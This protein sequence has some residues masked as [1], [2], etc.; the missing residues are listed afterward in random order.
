MAA[1]KISIIIP[2]K[3]GGP[4]KALEALSAVD[5]PSDLIE[6]LIAYGRQPSCQRNQAALQAGGDILYFLDDDSRVSPQFLKRLLPHYA[7]PVVAAVGGPS[8]TPVED[9]ALQKAIGLALASVFGGGG[10]RNRY[11]KSGKARATADN[12]LILC[13]LSFRKDIF[14]EFGGLDERLY[15]NEENELMERIRKAGLLLIHDPDLAIHRSQRPTFMAFLKQMFGYGR[16]R[17]EQTYISGEIKYITLIPSLFLIYLCLLPLFITSVYVIPILCYAITIL[18]CSI[19]EALNAGAVNLVPRLL[20]VFPALHLA[21]GA[22]MIRGLISPRFRKSRPVADGV[23]VMRVKE[24]GQPL[25]KQFDRSAVST[26][27]T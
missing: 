25:S 10:V 19:F 12:E 1:R 3:P 18:C 20:C 14:H 9:A 7:D 16:G 11:R 17:A 26:R 13:N 2:V 8:L 23:T 21:Y 22:G 27:K 5:Y 6:F 4:V 24:F 15:P